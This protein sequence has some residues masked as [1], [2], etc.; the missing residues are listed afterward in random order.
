MFKDSEFSNNVDFI[1]NLWGLT[2]KEAVPKA[3]IIM[4][5]PLCDF[6]L[7]FV[8]LC[9]SINYILPQRATKV[10]TKVNKGL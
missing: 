3:P 6:V 4:F 9:G 1:N 7:Y 2:V 5:L 8:I 10:V